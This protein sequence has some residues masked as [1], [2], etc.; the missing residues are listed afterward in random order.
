MFQGQVAI[1]LAFLFWESLEPPIGDFT[2]RNLVIFQNGIAHHEHFLPFLVLHWLQRNL[3]QLRTLDMSD[4]LHDSSCTKGITVLKSTLKFM[5]L[6]V[7]F[8]RSKKPRGVSPLSKPTMISECLTSLKSAQ[9]LYE[10]IWTWHFTQAPGPASPKIGWNW[11]WL[12]AV[13]DAN[14]KRV[15]CITWATFHLLHI[16]NFGRMPRK[17]LPNFASK[18]GDDLEGTIAFLPHFVRK[19]GEQS[20][21]LHCDLRISV[22]DSKKRILLHTCD[23]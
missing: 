5:I 4:E 2:L 3:Q 11:Y 16:Q 12:L 13:F 21:P 10:A 14:I 18:H 20:K 9:R 15:Q 7:F 1:P 22:C 6:I 23:S 8:G 17:R 19:T